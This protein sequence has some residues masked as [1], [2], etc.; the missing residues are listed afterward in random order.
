PV[1]ILREDRVPIHGGAICARDIQGR[2]DVFRRDAVQGLGER[3]GLRPPE[4]PH[5]IDRDALGLVKGD[6]P[7][8]RPHPMPHVSVRP[9]T[10]DGSP[11]HRF[12]TPI[13]CPSSGRISFSM[14]SRDASGDPG[15]QKTSRPWYTPATAPE[16]IAA[17][18]IDAYERDRKSSPN[19][20]KIRSN[21]GNRVGMV[22]S[23]FAS[24]V[25]PLVTMASQVQD[26]CSTA[27]RMAFGSSFTTAVKSTE[28]PD[29]W[30]R[31]RISLPDSS[32]CAVRLSEIVIT[33]HFTE[34]GAPSISRNTLRSTVP[35]GTTRCSISWSTT[36]RTVSLN[37]R[38]SR[39]NPVGSN[40]LR[41]GRTWRML[42]RRTHRSSAKRRR[43]NSRFR[44]KVFFVSP[45]QPSTTTRPTK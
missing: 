10:L 28:W 9:G 7:F 11:A 29:F 20:G 12:I 1:R 44:S 30:N 3:H 40:S 13:A 21:V 41:T 18:P 33:A 5:E 43:K 35:S 27:S 36:V 8:Q 39:Y 24:P 22:T 38:N 2:S 25:P 26:A 6:E 45:S 31:S 32:V 19:P 17:L 4:G 16:S 15:T 14:A 23:R 42:I 37:R 34:A